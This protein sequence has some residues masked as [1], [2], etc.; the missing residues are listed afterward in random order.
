MRDTNRGAPSREKRQPTSWLSP[1]L[2]DGFWRRT[3][4]CVSSLEPAERLELRFL[5]EGVEV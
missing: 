3:G 4:H 2:G 5:A 1:E